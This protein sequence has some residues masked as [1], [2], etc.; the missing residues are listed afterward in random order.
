MSVQGDN[1]ASWEAPEVAM[2]DSESWVSIET[3]AEHLAVSKDTIRRWIKRGLPA[4]RV[5]RFWR[6]RLSEVDAWVR[7][8]GAADQPDDSGGDGR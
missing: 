1:C 6:L 5:G 8:A 2:P 4:H 7:D 3:V